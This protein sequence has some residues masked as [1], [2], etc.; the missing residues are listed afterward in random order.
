LENKTRILVAPLNWGLG[1][2]TRCIPIIN[3]LLQSGIEV[4][5][6][7]DGKALQILRSEFPDLAHVEL[8]S[9]GSNYT[10]NLFALNILKQLPAMGCAIRKEQKM[11]PELIRKYNLSAIISD[12]RFGLYSNSVPS[13]II[14]HQVEIPIGI[15]RLHWLGNRINQHFLKKFGKIWVPDFKGAFNLSGSMSHGTVIDERLQYLGPVSRMKSGPSTAKHE[16]LIVLSGTEPQRTT[17]EHILLRQLANLPYKTLLVQ[18]ITSRK[19]RIVCSNKLEMVTYMTGAELNQAILESGLIISRSGYT[20]IMDLA[21][22]G[23]KALLIPTPGQ[24]EQE[25]LAD[26]FDNLGIFYGVS[27]KQLNLFH[28]I[29][30][31]ME[32]SGFEV[33]TSSGFEMDSIVYDWLSKQNLLRKESSMILH[34]VAS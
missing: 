33:N 2:A 25:M 14:T 3:Y 27:Q 24:R 6:G 16:L 20:T 11:L 30:L 7:S 8:P 13:V 31:A 22:L 15:P 1:H 12:N 26:H 10:S 18:G 19:E 17:L 29:P 9:Y 32:Y 4:V 28:D 23:K 5:L 34:T 21:F